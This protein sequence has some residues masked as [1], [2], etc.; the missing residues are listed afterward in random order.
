MSAGIHAAHVF[1][2]GRIPKDLLYQKDYAL[3]NLLRVADILRVAIYY[4]TVVCYCNPLM[5][6]S[7]SLVLQASLLAK[8]GSQHSKHGEN[9][10]A[11]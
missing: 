11:S 6:T 7:Y 8:K 3:V 1:A 10:T 2:P 4:R 9:T 5:Q